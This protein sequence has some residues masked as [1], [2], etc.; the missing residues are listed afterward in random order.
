M[1]R[2]GDVDKKIAVVIPSFRVTASILKVI[3]EI[4][5]EVHRIYVV[6]DCCPDKTADLVEKECDD[7]RVR[8]IRHGEN[9]GVGG[10]VVSGYR[11]ALDEGMDIVVKIDGDGQMD[12]ALIGKFTRPIINGKADYTKGNRFSRIESLLQMPALRKA[13]N[14]MLSFVNKISSGYWNLMDPTNGYTAIHRTALALLPLE[15]IS[16]GYFFESDMLFRLGTI[17]AVVRDVPMDA[18]YADEKSH[19]NIAKVFL[20][21]IPLYLSC[22]LKRVVYTY[23]LRDFSFATIEMVTGFVLMVFGAVFGASAWIESGRAGEFA[24]TGTVMI[25]VLPL[26]IGFQLLLNALNYDIGHV[27]VIPLQELDD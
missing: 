7:P 21:F 10:A 18:V 4:G 3:S 12:P 8:V 25:A 15:K 14:A 24:S 1:E 16:K 17:R 23:F 2:S 9:Q 22:F 19:L 5:P 6:D 20:E 13:G 11:A 26:I 27:P